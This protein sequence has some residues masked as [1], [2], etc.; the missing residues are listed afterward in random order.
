MSVPDPKLSYYGQPILPAGYDSWDLNGDEMNGP[1][2]N[3]PIWPMLFDTFEPKQIVIMT[4]EL[5][6]VF[7]GCA[8]Y[9]VPCENT[10]VV[11][12]A[13]PETIVIRKAA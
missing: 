12:P 3:E 8:D 4:E 5:L 13:E 7:D 2:V 6:E 9:V 11:F 10:A 1:G